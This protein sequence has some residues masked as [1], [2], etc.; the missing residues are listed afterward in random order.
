VHTGVAPLLRD[1]G[2]VML[3]KPFTLEGLRAA[4]D[5]SAPFVE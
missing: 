3:R 4:L 5:A 1:G 2:G